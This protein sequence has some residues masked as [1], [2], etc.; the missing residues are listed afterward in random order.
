MSTLLLVFGVFFT[1][2]GCAE[3]TDP[4]ET[5]FDPVLANAPIQAIKAGPGRDR[6]HV[7]IFGDQELS[8][9]S[10]G[11]EL[12]Y[13]ELLAESFGW[14]VDVTLVQDLGYVAGGLPASI[15]MAQVISEQQ[16]SQSGVSDLYVLQAGGADVGLTS[17]ELVVGVQRSIAAVRTVAPGVP[18]VVVGLLVREMDSRADF[19]RN[20]SDI[21]RVALGADGVGFVPTY[22]LNLDRFGGVNVSTRGR[23]GSVANAI[24]QYL[25]DNHVA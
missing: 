3:P 11:G 22:D 13:P 24:E 2:S 9:A 23:C 16:I 15:P 1:A 7:Q 25:R 20:Y 19:D 10:C 21:A 12:P 17:A 14:D 4:Y 5:N 18:I 8:A 6:P